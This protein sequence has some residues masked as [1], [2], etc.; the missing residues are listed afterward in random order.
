MDG[1]SLYNIRCKS[2][3]LHHRLTLDECTEKLQDYADHFYDDES[4]F[5]P[6][7]LKIEEII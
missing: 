3:I 5:D 6:K 4:A 7:D 2:D 1:E